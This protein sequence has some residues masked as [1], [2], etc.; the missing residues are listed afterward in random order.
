VGLIEELPSEPS[1][2]GTNAPEFRDVGAPGVTPDTR[3]SR[4]RRLLIGGAVAALAVLALL[5]AGALDGLRADNSPVWYDSDGLHHGD[6]VKVVPGTID[7]A[8][9]TL[10]RSGA[11]LL[12]RTSGDVWLYPWR[13]EPRRLG[14][15]STAGPGGDPN[16]DT[17][18]W[19]E[20]SDLVVYDVSRDSVISRT[21]PPGKGVRRLEPNRVWDMRPGSGFLQVT[22]GRVLWVD[23]GHI[24][25][26]DPRAETTSKLSH[27]SSA[28]W[29][30][31]GLVDVQDQVEF[32]VESAGD[33]TMVLSRPGNPDLR[34]P[35]LWPAAELS[36]TG[37]HALVEEK[38]D[39]KLPTAILDTRSGEL[40]R[41][42]AT[43]ISMISWSYGDIALAQTNQG[44]QACDANTR[45]CRVLGDELLPKNELV[46]IP[47]S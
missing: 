39:P 17:V 24:Y 26:H 46:L 44:L 18:A 13:G 12:D 2:P 6:D 35:R 41:V 45:Q 15:G 29:A 43:E 1:P 14:E 20:G 33:V 31:W 30:D 8:A 9:L 40:W 38:V 10:V 47:S 4:R 27:K 25:S 37:N 42:D 3:Q 5:D 16:S 28:S 11:V 21:N 19:F 32:W 7:V 34:L 23:G 36:P 22:P